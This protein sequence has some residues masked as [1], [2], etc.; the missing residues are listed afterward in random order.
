MSVMR[1]NNVRVSGQG[2]RPI[3]FAHGYGCEQSMWRY[4]P[5]AC[6]ADRRLV[7]VDHAGFGQAVPPSEPCAVSRK[8]VAAIRA[9]LD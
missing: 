1:K 7:P 6:E 2:N 8:T 4:L 9:W 3:L 5:P